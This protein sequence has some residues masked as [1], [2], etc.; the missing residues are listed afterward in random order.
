MNF[1]VQNVLKLGSL[2]A[3]YMSWM[4]R[5]PML[6]HPQPKQALVIC[7]GTGQTA[8]AVRQEGP[9]HLTIVDLSK[10]VF[11]LAPKFPTN[12]GVLDDPRVSHVT[13]DGRAWLRRTNE[14]YDVVTLEPLPPTF[15]GMNALYSR[16]FYQ[17]VSS[18]LN[19]GG[20]VAQWMP[21]HLLDAKQ[22]AAIAAT[23]CE[24]YPDAILWLD[25]LD[26]TGIL[27][28]RKGDGPALEKNWPGLLRPSSGRTLQPEAIQAA[29]VLNAAALERFA[30]SGVV[31]TD[32]NQ[33]LAYSF[34]LH[35]GLTNPQ[36]LAGINL[37]RVEA[38]RKGDTPPP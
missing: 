35:P 1:D 19:P 22:A 30:R 20:I 23:F 32:D 21:F 29:A 10:A 18:R 24:A 17:L 15:A 31:I 27:L 8:N 28:G 33:R 13:M 26:H 5:L 4:G 6:Q 38:A 34:T 11:E 16:E 14:T 25:P 37:V 12:H 3:D 9:E 36:E 2:A 7:F